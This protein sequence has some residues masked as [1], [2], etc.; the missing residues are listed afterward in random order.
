MVVTTK[1]GTQRKRHKCID[2]A[3]NGNGLLDYVQQAG[4]LDQ[5]L[6]G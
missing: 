2:G 3:I 5:R 4:C 6:L 1:V